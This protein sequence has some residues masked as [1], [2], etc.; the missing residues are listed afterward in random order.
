MFFSKSI[1]PVDEACVA[2]VIML[3]AYFLGSLSFKVHERLVP[4]EIY[5]LS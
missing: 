1:T 4:F 5:M 3:K 2:K